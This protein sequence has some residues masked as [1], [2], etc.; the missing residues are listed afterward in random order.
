MQVGQ[1]PPRAEEPLIVLGDIEGIIDTSDIDQ[2]I[3]IIVYKDRWVHDSRVI[4]Q[5]MRYY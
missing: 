1:R 3:A 5:V 2:D 4:R